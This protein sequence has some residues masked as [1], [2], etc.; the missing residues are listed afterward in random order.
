MPIQPSRVRYS[1]LPGIQSACDASVMEANNGLGRRIPWIFCLAANGAYIAFG[2]A[3]STDILYTW[4]SKNMLNEM[5][6]YADLGP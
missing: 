5:N 1:I 4:Q 2:V 6:P 3:A